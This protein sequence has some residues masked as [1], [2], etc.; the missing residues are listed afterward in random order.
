ARVYDRESALRAAR[1]LQQKGIQIVGT[2][3]GDA[4][5]WLLWG[6]EQIWLPKV[7]VQSV[8]ATGAG[9][10]FAAALAVA[11]AEGQQP[12]MAGAFCNAAAA[13]TTTKLGAQPAL[14]TRKEV[15]DLL[16]RSKATPA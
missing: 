16:K 7:P 6:N 2:Q 12:R 9:D 3:A 14:P 8:D 4:G 13:L 15:E 10:A 1:Q 5:N 11:I